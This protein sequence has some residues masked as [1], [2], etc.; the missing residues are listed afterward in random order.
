ME[1]RHLTSVIGGGI[2]RISENGQ[3]TKTLLCFLFG[4][5]NALSLDS[6]VSLPFSPAFQTRAPA[7][8]ECEI[9]LSANLRSAG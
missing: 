8:H 9:K 7:G 5:S 4:L 3:R 1:R 2:T 6:L